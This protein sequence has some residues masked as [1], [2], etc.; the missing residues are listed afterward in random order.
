[1][2]HAPTGAAPHLILLATFSVALLAQLGLALVARAGRRP[3]AVVWLLPLVGVLYAGAWATR[4]VSDGAREAL[5][6]THP[7]HLVTAGA[8]AWSAVLMSDGIGFA[9]LC[10]ASMLTAWLVA[11]GNVAGAGPRA[12][13]RWARSAPSLAV[14]TVG[15]SLL[16]GVGSLLG[17]PF[18]GFASGALLL[19]GHVASAMLAPWRSTD[20][21]A[22]QRLCAAEGLVVG[23]T[24]LALLAGTAAELSFLRART[25]SELARMGPELRPDLL[26]AADELS[27]AVAGIGLLGM[28]ITAVAGAF[29]VLTAPG[30]FGAWRTVASA[31]IATLVALGASGARLVEAG[32]LSDLAMSAHGGSIAR[33]PLVH[34]VDL[35]RAEDLAG[36]IDVA[37]A[38]V[39]TCL[40]VEGGEGWEGQPLH[41]VLDTNAWILAHGTPEHPVE[42][43]ERH[44]GCPPEMAAL[45][46]PLSTHELPVVA[47]QAHRLAPALTGHRW[48]LR[49]GSLRLL[50]APTHPER[51]PVS[52]VWRTV[53][54]RWEM[55]PE[56]GP[57]GDGDDVWDYEAAARLPVTLMEGAGPVLIAGGSRENLPEGE[58]G[59]ERLRDALLGAEVRDLVLVPRKYWTIQDLVRFCLTVQGHVEDA[60]CVVRPES[61]A[62]WSERTGLPLPWA[63]PSGEGG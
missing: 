26:A 3:P 8:Q 9:V 7:E 24:L 50:L 6:S 14:G 12:R 28:G 51:S 46:G 13:S 61:P 55:P 16:A 42:E 41:P 10:V 20:R 32:S 44:P 52:Q 63:A 17:V 43:L 53:E 30:G 38:A 22:D 23:S 29:A 59:V 35:P 27:R 62:R 31:S 54:L 19:A 1:M 37:P 49:D 47:V 33:Q 45:A 36:P 48:F 56:D 11:F 4:S 40:V 15:A 60:R 25:W 5:A 58:E 21:R 2:T 57:V 34:L 18:E 39:G